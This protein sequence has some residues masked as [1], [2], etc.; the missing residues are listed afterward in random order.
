MKTKNASLY[1]FSGLIVLYSKHPAGS[2]VHAFSP[3]G[4][5]LKNSLDHLFSGGTNAG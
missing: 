3:A 5:F 4:G 1:F 2:H